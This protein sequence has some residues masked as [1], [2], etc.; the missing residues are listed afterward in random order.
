[1]RV[2]HPSR[3]ALVVNRLFM[4]AF[5]AAEPPCL[6]LGMV[7]ERQRLCSMLTLRLAEAIPSAI[8]DQG[9]EFGHSLY[10]TAILG[11]M[12]VCALPMEHDAEGTPVV[13][14]EY[15]GAATAAGNDTCGTYDSI[16]VWNRS[17][18]TVTYLIWHPAVSNTT[19]F[20]ITPKAP[21]SPGIHAGDG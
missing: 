3:P 2:A 1:M 13:T 16:F 5:L 8:A 7:E 11:L 17:N 14:P 19:W 15:D 18:V 20:W 6:A 9:F 21:R 12:L 4:Q 10:L